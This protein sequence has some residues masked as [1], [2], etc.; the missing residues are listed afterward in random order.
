MGAK[1][2]GVI[3]G[4]CRDNEYADAAQKEI[5]EVATQQGNVHVHI[6]DMSDPRAVT[7]F[8]K[9]FQHPVNV[10]INN[11]GCMVNQ[12]TM[13]EDGL[14]KNFATNTLG[15]HILTEKFILKLPQQ[16]Q[17]KTR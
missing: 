13:T 1:R 3:H 5:Q 14:E 12:R 11:A 4:V 17:G 16:T 9:E 10:L 7:K 2:G 6:L 15:T 8:A